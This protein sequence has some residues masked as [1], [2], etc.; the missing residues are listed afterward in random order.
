MLRT[1]NDKR[2]EGRRQRDVNQ[3]ADA[4][5]SWQE[6]KEWRMWLGISADQRQLA[7][8]LSALGAGR[9]TQK[10]NMKHARSRAGT[11]WAAQVQMLNPVRRP[12]RDGEATPAASASAAVFD[13]GASEYRRRMT[14]RSSCWAE[15]IKREPCA[16]PVPAVPAKELLPRTSERSALSGTGKWGFPPVTPGQ[17]LYA[18]GLVDQQCSAVLRSVMRY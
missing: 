6:G 17:M 5:A 8:Y 3:L 4:H 18:Q 14:N 2:R 7:G 9:A 1:P 13:A 12:A 10:Q 16:Q 11:A 15:P